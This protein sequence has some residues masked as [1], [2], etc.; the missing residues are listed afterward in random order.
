MIEPF[1]I[2]LRLFAIQERDTGFG[3]APNATQKRPNW[4]PIHMVLERQPRIDIVL[5]VIAP[6]AKWQE[7]DI[8]TQQLLRKLSSVFIF[9]QKKTR[10]IIEITAFDYLGAANTPDPLFFF[11]EFI[12]DI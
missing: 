1:L 10:R 5:A 9:Q 11:K 6:I 4:H 8:L 2:I 3:I 12:G 7:V